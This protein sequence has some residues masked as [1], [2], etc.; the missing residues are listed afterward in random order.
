MKIAVDAMGG[1]FA[2]GEIVQGSVK[3]SRDYGI[4]VVLVGDKAR[5]K[6]E[7]RNQAAEKELSVVNASETIGMN[8]SPVEAVRQKRD[9]SIV[10]CTELVKE[11]TAQAVVSAGS[12]GAVMTASL[13]TWGR[14]KNIGRPSIATILPNRKGSTLLL[15]AGANT[16]C[17]PKHLL[18]FSIMGSLYANLM[19]GK[20][21]PRIGLLSIGEEVTKGNEL[22]LSAYSLIEGSGLNFAGNIEGRDIFSGNVDVIICDGF[23]GNVVLKTGEGMAKNLFGLL[24]EEIQK[25]F[26][27]RIGALMTLPVLK[28]LKSKMDYAEYG[29]AP[30]LGV[31]GITI[32]AHG[33]S[34]SMA[35]K[36]AIKMARDLAENDIVNAIKKGA[37]EVP[38]RQV[39]N[40]NA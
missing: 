1:D 34:N 7:L 8:E 35:V 3:A 20:E 4:D 29:G 27:A 16:D 14:I 32:I 5:V 31:N 30:L 26:I 40:I 6:K 13:L 25:N 23:V 10:K 12:T 36:N 21:T 33:S 38:G 17:R 15:D 22:T 28:N 39:N 2:P 11:G 19:M 18:Q 9:S 37:S 24:R